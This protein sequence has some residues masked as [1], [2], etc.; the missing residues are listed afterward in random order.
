[1]RERW[2]I[3]VI[4]AILGL[5]AAFAVG[6]SSPPNYAATA[7]LF[8]RVEATDTNLLERSQFSLA[9]IKS[10]VDL[11]SSPSV[12]QKTINDLNLEV[13]V[14]ALAA[15]VHAD[16]PTDTVLLEV[17][18]ESADPRQA[19][20]I[21]NSVARNLAANI[22]DLETETAD[23]RYAIMLDLRIPADNARSTTASQLAVLL[24]LG[25][26]GGLA[27]GV[28]IAALLV[29]LDP[30]VRTTE[31]VRRSSGLPVVGQ[32]PSS[33]R[34]L[35]RG[36]PFAHDLA[37]AFRGFVVDLRLLTG[38]ID[39]RLLVLVPTS[40]RDR[41]D[42]VRLGLARTMALSG[43]SVAVVTLDPADPLAPVRDTE[44]EMNDEAAD[45][46]PQQ[47][48]HEQEL[49]L[50]D[51]DDDESTEL[52][53]SPESEEEPDQTT[54]GAFARAA[55]T[56]RS[57]IA[58]AAHRMRAGFTRRP[59]P[60]PGEPFAVMVAGAPAASA[61]ERET[62]LVDLVNEGAGNADTV[63][64]TAREVDE[65]PALARLDGAIVV[66]VVDTRV[67]KRTRLHSVS[68]ALEFAG[69]H[70]AGVVMTSVSARRR[71]DLP[72]TWFEGD[73]ITRPERRGSVRTRRS[74]PKPTAAGGS[75]QSSR[76]GKSEPAGRVG[77]A[78]LTL[79]FG[80]QEAIAG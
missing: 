49:L 30:R 23:G 70:P 74:G 75:K 58:T 1:L 68:T 5:L 69:V 56:V 12:L 48:T 16:N 79:D 41:S 55:P 60:V 62:A 35:R 57:S 47:L 10:Y 80:E 24:G 32:L 27:V 25:L 15:D 43:L 19:A 38:G 53:A 28:V 6:R 67:T 33:L 73:R 44:H 45:A 14:E 20:L 61:R 54:P 37:D 2:Y 42:L 4:A 63:I 31:D 77:P 40:P 72:S 36:K 17:T 3:I 11:V 7:T 9:R 52:P 18:A 76:A 64:L 66:V 26:L 51:A 8:L 59:H 71:D 46:E 13:S 39:P 65:L 21:A 78:D 22:E 34:R 29:V 50:V